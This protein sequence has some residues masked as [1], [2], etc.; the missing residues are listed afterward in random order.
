M[1]SPYRKKRWR[2]V[3]DIGGANFRVELMGRNEGGTFLRVELLIP[4]RIGRKGQFG[5]E[6]HA[7]DCLSA[8]QWITMLRHYWFWPQE[9]VRATAD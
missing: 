6:S 5:L 4:R 3:S 9:W 8:E 2:R 7:C 1:R